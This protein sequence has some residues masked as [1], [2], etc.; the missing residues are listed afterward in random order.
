MLTLCSALQPTSGLRHDRTSALTMQAISA[1]KLVLLLM[2]ALENPFM[3][4]DI[5][6]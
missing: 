6:D 4:S 3:A 5:G 1:L 2:Q